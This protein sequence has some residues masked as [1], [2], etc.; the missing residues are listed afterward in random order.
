MLITV[1][2]LVAVLSVLVFIHELGHFATAKFF[3]IKVEE[4]GFGFPPRIWGFKHGDTNYTINWIPLGGFVRIKGE[5]GEDAADKDSFGARPIWQRALVLCAGVIMNFVLAWAI[6]T[7]PP[8]AAS[9]PWT[10]LR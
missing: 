1:L 8:A 5:N 6:M 4:F 10:S 2:I 7:G 9:S 3:G